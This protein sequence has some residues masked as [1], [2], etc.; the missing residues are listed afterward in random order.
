MTWK[1][2]VYFIQ[3]LLFPTLV[4]A[5]A[6]QIHEYRLANGLKLIV[7]EDHRSPVVLSSIWYKVGGSYE[8]DGMTGIS[9]VLEHMMFRGTK[10]YPAGQF[11][12]MISENGGQQN[13]MTTDDQTMYY[14]QLAADKLPLSFRL[15]ADRMQHLSLTEKDFEKEIQ[16][17]MEER[18]MRVDDNPNAT[19]VERFNAAAYVNNPYHHPTIGWMTDLQHMTVENVR[20]WYRTWYVPN[21]A[22]VVVVGDVTPEK[23]YALAKKY[24]GSIPAVKLP[25][26]KPR[27]EISSL[28]LILVNVQLPAKLPLLLL[29]YPTPSLVGV[30]TIWHPYAL[31]VLAAIL[32]GS[33]SSRFAK[34]LVRHQQIATV[35][36]AAYNPYSLH[37]N[38]LTLVGIPSQGHR[39]QALKQAFLQQIKELQTTL[40]SPQ[41]MERVKAQVIAQNVYNKDSLMNQAM[42]IGT[43]ESIGLSWRIDQVYVKRIQAVTAEQVQQVAKIYLLPYALTVGVLHPQ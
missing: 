34:M 4:F 41:E 28:G 42:D 43:P 10:H 33:D 22:I 1:G 26:L 37:S 12:K 30:N 2:M 32:G 23:V 16:V 11:E 7:K 6:D 40:V 15:E 3:I 9:H 36:Q 5:T 31:A 25:P 35:A 24:F 39:G 13:A 8:Q 14:Q 20:D 21:N 29:G 38:L 17:V 27:I 18:R 19:T